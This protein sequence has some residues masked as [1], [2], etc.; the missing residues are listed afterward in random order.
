LAGIHA[1]PLRELLYTKNTRMNLNIRVLHIHYLTW[2]LPISGPQGRS[3]A[4][5]KNA[6]G[7]WWALFRLGTPRSGNISVKD[8]KFCKFLINI[9]QGLG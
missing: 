6:C 3:L 7:S 8:T 9:T 4:A 1:N 2:R 5:A